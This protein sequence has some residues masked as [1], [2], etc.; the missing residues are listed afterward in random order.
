MFQLSVQVPGPAEMLYDLPSIESTMEVISSRSEAVPSI[1][2]TFDSVALLVGKVM[3]IFGSA[4][5]F[6]KEVV[7]R[8]TTVSSDRAVA[9][10]F[11]M[12]IGRMHCV[13]AK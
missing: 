9:Q 10:R 11:K 5:L 12:F 8:S 3:L 13:L 1:V 2:T 7:G 6:A 4:V